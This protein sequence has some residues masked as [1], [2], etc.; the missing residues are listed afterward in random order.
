MV[1]QLPP[2]FQNLFD[3]FQV[4]KP[5]CGT[6]FTILS[7]NTWPGKGFRAIVAEIPHASHD[8]QQFR[9]VGKYSTALNGMEELGGMK[10]GGTDVAIGK[11]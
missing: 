6:E 9:A 4:T 7:I 8:F 11:Y 10:T 2:G 1:G 5:H 3:V